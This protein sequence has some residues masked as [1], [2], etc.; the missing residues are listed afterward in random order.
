MRYATTVSVLSMA[1]TIRILSSS[2][3]VMQCT[4]AL[5]QLRSIRP[6]RFIIVVIVDILL[7]LTWMGQKSHQ[8]AIKLSVTKGWWI[9]GAALYRTALKLVTL[10]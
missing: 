5:N 10:L 2:L 7:L 9:G 6:R 3:Q 8:F 4:R 1:E